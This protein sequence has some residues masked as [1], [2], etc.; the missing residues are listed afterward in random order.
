MILIS[1]QILKKKKVQFTNTKITPYA[2]YLL[3][4]TTQGSVCFKEYQ[5]VSFWADL[6]HVNNKHSK[7]QHKVVFD[8]VWK[9]S[10]PKQ[11]TKQS[12]STKLNKN[13]GLSGKIDTNC[14]FA[15]GSS[16][17]SR[18]HCGW[19][20]YGGERHGPSERSEEGGWAVSWPWES[21]WC[22]AQGRHR[23]E[24]ALTLTPPSLLWS[25]PM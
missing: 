7:P 12:L 23:K 11:V 9:I 4:I 8:Y 18:Q 25:H 21:R 17:S 16:S 14:S 19:V 13:N 24:K 3:I 15:H 10:C 2:L 5:R 22:W 1:R 6:F 20:C